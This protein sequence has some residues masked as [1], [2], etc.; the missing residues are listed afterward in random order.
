MTFGV[1]AAL[2]AVLFDPGWCAARIAIA[3][4]GRP[5]SLQLNVR[6]HE[7]LDPANL[8]HARETVYALLESVGIRLDWQECYS[9]DTCAP[10]AESRAVV[11]LLLPFASPTH[12]GLSGQVVE[13]NRSR[14]TTI[15]VYVS[16][17]ADLA[18]A[19]RSSPL[20]RSDSRLA[21]VHTGH[22]VGL[23]IAHEV[24]HALL[25]PHTSSGLMQPEFDLDDV[26]AMREARL[27]FTPSEG[28]ILR[29]QLGRDPARAC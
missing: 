25:L 2:L 21:T 23:T 29:C 20:G 5:P 15:N 10:A 14:D 19:I 6:V 26:R 7:S 8:K 1:G 3:Q 17:L 27:A 9:G 28:A 13:D 22:L 24:G 4:S 12:R 11:V 16:V 18:R